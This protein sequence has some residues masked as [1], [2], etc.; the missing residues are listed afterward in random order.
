MPTRR[1]KPDSLYVLTDNI[2]QYHSVRLIIRANFVLNYQHFLS[3]TCIAPVLLA[4]SLQIVNKSTVSLHV[5]LD[6]FDDAFGSYIGWSKS[7]DN[8]SFWVIWVGIDLFGLPCDL[9]VSK[10]I[11]RRNTFAIHHQELFVEIYTYIN[12]IKSMLPFIVDF[13]LESKFNAAAID[14]AS[15]DKK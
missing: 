4:L 15:V 13:V 10:G 14:L 8:F 5:E 11:S 2:T 12:I 6:L 3:L 9:I 7:Q 1:K